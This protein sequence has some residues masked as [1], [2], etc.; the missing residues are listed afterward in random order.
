MLTNEVGRND[1]CRCGSGKKYKKCCLPRDEQAAT[2]P[3]QPWH[4][5]DDRLATDVAQY[6]GRRFREAWDE[7]IDE[8]PVDVEEDPDH[9]GILTRWAAYEHELEGRTAVEWYLEERGRNLAGDER[10]WLEAQGRACLSVLEV[11]EVVP[12][13]TIAVVDLLTGRRHTVTEAAASHT[14]SKGFLLL[15]RVVEHE[16]FALLAGLHPRPLPPLAGPDL[17]DEARRDLDI[18]KNVEPARLKEGDAATVLLRRWQAWVDKLASRRPV[19]LSNTDGDELIWTID[20]FAFTSPAAKAEIETRL[21]AADDVEG[22]PPGDKK[23]IYSFVR[24]TPGSDEVTL[25]GTARVLSRELRVESTSLPRADALR[26]RL[27]TMC[28]GLIRHRARSA[29]NI[30]DLLAARISEAPERPRASNPKADAR[31][32]E[33]KRRYYATWTGEPIPALDGLTPREAAASPRS[34][35]RLVA[36]LKDMEL[37]E[38]NE[39]SGQRFDFDVIRAELGIPT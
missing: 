17:L 7:V 38:S 29:E 23:R 5:L 35:A 19:E 26:A 16:G 18:A 15:G 10:R 36:L 28:D 31:A 39:P 11:T 32:L 14:V 12:G 3:A 22:P 30:E 33:T 9:I 8:Y 27:E 4:D 25:V 21:A 20:T 37:T 6:A 24:A 1:P 13:Q 2:S 34:R